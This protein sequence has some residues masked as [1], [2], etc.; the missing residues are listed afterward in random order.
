MK[1]RTRF[2]KVARV[3]FGMV[4]DFYREAR[5]IRRKGY[6]FSQKKMSPVHE[7]RARQ[8]YDM[9][10]A[11]G[12]LHIKLCQFF[13]ARRDIFPEPY[14]R[15]LARLQDSVPPVPFSAIEQV[16][17]EEY[18]D[19]RQ[20][21]KEI[22]PV[23]LASASLG[24]VHKAVLHDG[25]EVAL[26]I[27]KPG[28]KRII[29][30]DFAIL[31]YVFRLLSY[32]R[33]IREHADL[34]N[35]LDEFVAVTSD[36]LNFKREAHIAARFREQLQKLPYVRIPLIYDAYCTAHVIVME[37]LTGDKI[38]DVHAWESRGNDPLVLSRRIIE[39]YFEQFLKTGLIHFD[40]HPGN[41]LVTD[42][43]CLVLLD[44]GMSGEITDRMRN[45]IRELIRGVII[46]DYR[47]VLDV[48][49]QLGFIRKGVN[50]YSLLPVIEFF[51]DE[52]LHVLKLNRESIHSADVSPIID[53]LVEIV[54]EHPIQIPA[55]WAY[56]GKTIGT[57]AGIVATLHPDCN[58]YEEIKPYADQ[59]LKDGILTT[60]EKGVSELG[61][62]LSQLYR[63]PA[64]ANEFMGNIERGIYT[65]RVDMSDIDRKAN[66]L[67]VFVVRFFSFVISLF[68]GAGAYL[69]YRAGQSPKMLVC[70]VI[71]VFF[72]LLSIVYRKRSVKERM[73]RHLAPR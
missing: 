10:I 8:F 34:F 64:R 41:I 27:L 15:I 24:Q 12:G 19:W 40:P 72:L 17:Q 25:R 39:L 70:S 66:E 2:F 14:I 45:G 22:D 9:A 68:S 11:L 54:Y 13:S 61:E 16:L 3:F 65:F 46:R 48:L 37:F 4:R 7:K 42:D 58:V 71:A 23:P 57:L 69:F 28:V 18:D 36:E 50:K 20:H 30:I 43:N 53:D 32:S 49:D 73:K 60:I 52:L 35:L 63:L 31:F 62:N 38:S 29:D 5:L 67:M 26:K 59:I 47:L 51:F 44:F 1:V 21:F 56:I 33:R 55:N 6:A